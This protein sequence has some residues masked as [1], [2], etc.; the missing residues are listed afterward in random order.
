MRFIALT[1]ALLIN[2][3]AGVVMN[4]NWNVS[5]A[6][7]YNSLSIVIVSKVI[8]HYAKPVGNRTVYKL[9]NAASFAAC[10][11]TGAIDLTKP[12]GKTSVSIP[13]IL[14]NTTLYFADKNSC[15]LGQKMALAAIYGY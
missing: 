5:N 13:A 1:F 11:F 3:A 4:I 6:A 10:N 9:A 12:T 2:F 8:F 7:A 15:A 14:A